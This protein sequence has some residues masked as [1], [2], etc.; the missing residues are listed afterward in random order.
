[1]HFGNVTYGTWL[2]RTIDKFVYAQGA[3]GVSCDL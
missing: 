1:M 2:Y 3:A